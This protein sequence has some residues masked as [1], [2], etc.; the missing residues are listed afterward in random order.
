MYFP[1]R[2]APLRGSAAGV[3]PQA[4]GLAVA[5]IQTGVLMGQRTVRTHMHRGRG[6]G[7]MNLAPLWRGGDEGP[8]GQA[9]SLYRSG[10]DSIPGGVE[11]ALPQGTARTGRLPVAV[12]QQSAL[13]GGRPARGGASSKGTSAFR[14]R[15]R[16]AL[17]SSPSS[18]CYRDAV[19]DQTQPELERG[20]E[21]PLVRQV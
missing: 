12:W 5:A 2:E 7:Y 11:I 9:L 17:V 6:E 4:H 16:R 8:E 20:I 18:C 1:A 14:A 3:D 10:A 15:R 19:Q 13:M 21:V